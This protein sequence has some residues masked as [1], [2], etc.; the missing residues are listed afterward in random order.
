MENYIGLIAQ[1]KAA[2]LI[3]TAKAVGTRWEDG[4]E[5]TKAYAE[6]L[7]RTAGK[8]DESGPEHG[9]DPRRQD[10]AAQLRER[11]ATVEQTDL[12]E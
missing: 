8:L 2:G 11:A 9:A 4:G 1:A 5:S 6:A 12:A 7:R 3:A 10:L